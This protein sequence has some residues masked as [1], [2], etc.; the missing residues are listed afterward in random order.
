[1]LPDRIVAKIDAA[2]PCWLWTASTFQGYGQAYLGG[3]KWKAHRLVWELLVGSV[4]DGLELDHLCRVRRCVNPDHLELVTH[5]E[6]V[7]RGLRRPAMCPKGHLYD[8]ANTRYRLTGPKAGTRLC[9]EC[10]RAIS[11][12]Y[13]RRMRS[14]DRRQRRIAGL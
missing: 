12:R 9:R 1:V 2:G 10:Q 11:E 7:R 3:R 4:P 14:T 13:R 8:K 5:A 6:N